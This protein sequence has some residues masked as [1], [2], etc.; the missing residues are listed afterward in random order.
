MSEQNRIGAFYSRGTHYPRLLAYLRTEYPDCEITAVVPP[1]YP[2]H[3]LEDACDRI[4]RTPR[5]D[6]SLSD[7]RAIARVI[8]QLRGERFDDFVIMFNSAKL[9]VLAKASG[10]E[11]SYCYTADRR[12]FPVELHPLREGTGMLVRNIR[13]R[14]T[15]WRIAW[16]VKHRPVGK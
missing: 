5:E 10:A 2:G 1:N 15:Y 13:G 8:A 14:M 3:I 12:F 9:R 4:V 6:Y 16:I 7:P 11:S